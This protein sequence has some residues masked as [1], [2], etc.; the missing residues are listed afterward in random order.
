MRMVCSI[1]LLV[2]SF[3]TA[4][5]SF[6][7]RFYGN[8]VND[9]D[10]VKI[11]ID[12]PDISDDPSPPV[13]VG[14][15]DFTIEFWMKAASAYNTSDPVS[16]G[17]NNNWIYGN[18]IIDRDRYNQGR[19]YGI[20][21]AGGL[22]VFGTM[23][24]SGDAFTICSTTDVLDNDWHHIA[25]QR[26]RSDGWMWLYVDGILEANANGPNGDI[27]Y[28]DDGVPGDFCGGPCTNSDPYIVFGAEKHDAGPAFPSF[29]GYLDEVRFSGILRY[30]TNFTP[31][32]A[33]FVT[34][35]NTVGLYRFETG[36]GL[37]AYDDSGSGSPNGVIHFGGSP[38]GPVW[39]T[40]TP[41]TI[42]GLDQDSTARDV[43]RS[44]LA[45]CTVYPVPAR[46]H[47]FI[48]CGETWNVELISGNGRCIE[49]H[50][51]DRRIDLLNAT[52]GLYAMRITHAHGVDILPILVMRP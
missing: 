17:N 6:S 1:V 39:T 51:E 7:L 3:E 12:D 18:I 8:G 5:Q 35:G 50:A 32:S 13:D 2:L 26:R 19:N 16:C 27:S 33:P 25:L 22:I 24:S 21:V 41:F 49:I 29:N 10:R 45:P 42:L 34:D 30:S 47:V 40:D 23:G 38:P 43:P 44:M 28:P 48:D 37:V 11:Q 46:N 9:I 4:G 14:D 15:E 52:P 31:P 20:S 36:S